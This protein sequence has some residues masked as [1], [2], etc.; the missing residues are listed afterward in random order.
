[1][2][3]IFITGGTGKIGKQLSQHFIKEG[4]NVVITTRNLQGLDKIAA[5]CDFTEEQRS[6]LY[7]IKVDFNDTT[8]VDTIKSYFVD[9]KILLPH[10]L[11][12]NA[13]T[14]DALKVEESGFSHR[15]MLMMEYLIDVVIPYE[16][17]VLIKSISPQLSSIINVSS[18]YGLVPFNPNLYDNYPH[19]APIQYSLAKASLE[20]SGKSARM[21]S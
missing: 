17:S 10:V 16:I 21:T 11:V 3:N 7:G 14:L 6:R 1:M 12:N 4:W 19:G 13:R 9:N 15:S 18:I 8:C 5:A 20:G 2:K